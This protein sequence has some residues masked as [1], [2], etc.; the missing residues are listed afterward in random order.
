LI[1]TTIRAHEDSIESTRSDS[2]EEVFHDKDVEK[3]K[4]LEKEKESEKQV[5]DEP[6]TSPRHHEKH[7]KHDGHDK[8]EHR[9]SEK[10]HDK[11]HNRHDAKAESDLLADFDDSSQ[12]PSA[13]KKSK[14]KLHI[15]H[16]SD[17]KETL[18][19]DLKSSNKMTKKE[20]KKIEKVWSVLYF[21]LSDSKILNKSHYFDEVNFLKNLQIGRL[22]LQDVLHMTE[23][24]FL[25]MLLLFLLLFL[26]F[27]VICCCCCS[28]SCYYYLL[29]LLLLLLLLFGLLDSN[30]SAYLPLM[31]LFIR[32]QTNLLNTKDSPYPLM[33][34]YYAMRWSKLL[35][36]FFFRVYSNPNIGT[37]VSL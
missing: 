31:C 5:R 22:S 1:E 37:L 24:Y 23:K 12:V 9:K 28:C 15:L 32:K 29:L 30:I 18:Y 8:K 19:D 20:M 34:T 6:K 3:E 26:L 16:H 17:K 11:S 7:A 13:M 27:V 2:V 35:E 10:H 25:C 14:G 21:S 33:K 4:E 36:I